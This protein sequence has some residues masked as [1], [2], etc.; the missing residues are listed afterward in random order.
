MVSSPHNEFSCSII[1]VIQIMPVRF[2]Q[3]R[4]SHYNANQPFNCCCKINVL[5]AVTS[6][7]DIE[8]SVVWNL[9]W[10][11]FGNFPLYRTWRKW[12]RYWMLLYCDAQFFFVA[13]VREYKGT[14]IVRYDT[15]WFIV[16]HACL[17]TWTEE[18]TFVRHLQSKSTRFKS[19]MMNGLFWGSC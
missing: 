15:H 2:K 18:I 8:L 6:R 4:R 5:N 7:N 14:L 3:L 16:P 13:V 19:R 12:Y 10:Y 11:D 1:R 9:R 17:Y